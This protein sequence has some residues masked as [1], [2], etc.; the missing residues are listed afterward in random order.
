V[1]NIL[2]EKWKRASLVRPGVLLPCS[3]GFLGRALRRNEVLNLRVGG[4]IAGAAFILSFLI[5]LVNRTSMPMLIVRPLIFLALFFIITYLISV[6]V[7][8]FLPE[9]LEEGA[10]G[11][12]SDEFLPGSRVNIMEGDGE[13][14]SQNTF[15]GDGGGQSSVPASAMPSFMRDETDSTED[16][17][18][19]IAAF[20][21]RAAAPQFG[22][23]SVSTGIDQM[24][25]DDYTEP[26][27][28]TSNSNS[29]E[30]IN[31]GDM[32]LDLDSVAGAF[33]P[34]SQG[35]QGGEPDMVEHSVPTPSRKPLSKGTAPEWAGDFKPK[36]I[37]EGLRT[38]LNKNKEG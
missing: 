11:G 14:L 2:L 8:R 3:K 1:F 30:G 13:S 32:L 7:S 21:E 5:G 26:A 37:A 20:G 29:I 28:E 25:Q 24:G 6:L 17:L 12:L 18:G 16:R 38:I 4:I 33:M 27:V 35:S 36:E 34:A 10:P 31:S 22:E 23:V 9:L 15:M 19:D